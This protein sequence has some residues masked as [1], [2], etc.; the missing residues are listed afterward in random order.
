MRIDEMMAKK[1][2][3]P[4]LD[5]DIV[6]MASQLIFRHRWLRGFKCFT[7]ILVNILHANKI[8]DML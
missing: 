3:V 6:I 5:I 8:I 1:R 2:T 4:K 7:P